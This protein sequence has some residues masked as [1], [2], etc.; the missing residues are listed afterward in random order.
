MKNVSEFVLAL[1]PKE[2][3]KH[4]ELIKEC[5]SRENQLIEV[6][7]NTSEGVK[8]LEQNCLD[9]FNSLNSLYSRLILVQQEVTSCLTDSES[10]KA[11]KELLERK[12]KYDS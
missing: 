1:S 7:L 9:F 11:Y 2:R 8:R 3:E 12:G 10:Q 4:K 6:A 5:L